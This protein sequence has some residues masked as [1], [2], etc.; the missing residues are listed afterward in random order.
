MSQLE[1]VD[2]ADW[3]LMCGGALTFMI[4]GQEGGEVMD[5]DMR[6]DVF[7]PNK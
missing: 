1:R 2:R 4:G 6:K 7:I 5:H 3:S